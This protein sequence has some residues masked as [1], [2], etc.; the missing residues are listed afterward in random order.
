MPLSPTGETMTDTTYATIEEMRGQYGSVDSKFDAAIQTCLNAAAEA[1]DGTC[2]WNVPM[3]APAVATSR[4]YVGSGEAFQNIDL[5][6]SVTTVEIK[7][8]P[9]DASWTAL[10]GGTYLPFRG[11]PRF[12]DFNKIPYMGLLLLGSGLA[13]FPSGKRTEGF[14]LPTVRVTGRFGYGLELPANAKL[15]VLLQ[16]CRWFK[17]GE[18][19]WADAI[20]KGELG[21]LQFRK[22]LD[23]DYA[24]MIHNARLVKPTI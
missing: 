22:A 12:P 4:M 11:E 8:S 20:S 1:L 9:T 2:N 6:V 16:A 15:A 5:C 17:R 18:S 10:T 19:A 14:G 21:Q 13:T 7:A 23:P 3:L 24:A